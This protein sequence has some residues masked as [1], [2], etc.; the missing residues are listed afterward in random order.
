MSDSKKKADTRT[1]KGKS[2]GRLSRRKLIQ[3][4]ALTAGLGGAA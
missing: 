3:G 4:A 2:Q 1:P